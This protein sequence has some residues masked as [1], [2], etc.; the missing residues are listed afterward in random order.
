MVSCDVEE[1]IS[2]I[3]AKNGRNLYTPVKCG[4]G[5]IPSAFLYSTG[6]IVTAL[7]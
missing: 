7:G 3:F 1:N 6:S 5:L 2:G 4:T